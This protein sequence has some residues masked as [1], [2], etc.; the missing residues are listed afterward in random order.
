MTHSCGW[1]DAV[2][3]SE[4]TVLHFAV[5]QAVPTGI[6]EQRNFFSLGHFQNTIN[7]VCTKIIK[8]YIFEMPWGEPMVFITISGH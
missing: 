1:Y 7:T 3:Q 2:L 5:L 6:L 8:K 4:F